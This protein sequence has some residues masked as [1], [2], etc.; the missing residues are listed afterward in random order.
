MIN[1]TVFQKSIWNF[2]FPNALPPIHH[3]T[4]PFKEEQKKTFSQNSD[5]EC[6]KQIMGKKQSKEIEKDDIFVSCCSGI[7][8]IL[9]PNCMN[10]SF[11]SFRKPLFYETNLTFTFGLSGG[12]L[13][14]QLMSWKQVVFP[15]NNGIQILVYYSNCDLIKWY[16]PIQVVVLLKFTHELR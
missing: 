10:L 11:H 9:L 8:N 14:S 13:A 4:Q 12:P 15:I 3:I 6:Q 5:L 2:F 7:R 16:F 1:E